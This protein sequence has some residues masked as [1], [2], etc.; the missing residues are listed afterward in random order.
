[1][2]TGLQENSGV[3]PPLAEKKPVQFVAGFLFD[4]AGDWVLLIKK[5]R[6]AWQVGYLNGIGGR[7]E[8][9]ESAAEAMRRECVEEAGVDPEW[10]PYACVEY[11][12]C[13]LHFFAARDGTA[14]LD[15]RTMTDEDL[16]RLPAQG[17][18]IEMAQLI[19]N[20]RFL[21]PLARHHLLFE[22]V[23]LAHFY[24]SGASSAIARKM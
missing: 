10:S 22:K 1:M 23:V 16:V 20:L 4:E 19:P 13:I 21:I 6:P 7:I 24:I 2:E 12:G 8:P 15:A 5:R 14:Y 9:D 17:M 3:V 11:P 18:L